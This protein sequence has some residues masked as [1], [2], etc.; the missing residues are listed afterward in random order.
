MERSRKALPFCISL[1][2]IIIFFA[3]ANLVSSQDLGKRFDLGDEHVTARARFLLPKLFNFER[4]KEVFHKIYDNVIENLVR[5]RLYLGRTFRAFITAVSY[6]YCKTDFYLG[7]NQMS[8]WTPEEQRAT[9]MDNRMFDDKDELFNHI[10]DHDEEF[11]EHFELP[12]AD[13]KEIER[14]FEEIEEHESEEPGYKEISREIRRFKRDVEEDFRENFSVRDLIKK[15]EGNIESKEKFSNTGEEVPG[16][17]LPEPVDS[18][19]QEV[20]EKE[21]PE[22]K[23]LV[24][25]EA[26]VIA[27]QPGDHF[28][29]S[30]LS[31][32]TSMFSLSSRKASERTRDI[33]YHDY[34]KSHC[35]LP[36]KDQKGCSCCYAMAA[37]AMYEWSYCDQ[38]GKPLAL[39]EQYPI[40]C[41]Q[42]V[43]LDGCNF[44]K[45]DM[46]SNFTT[47]YGLN[48]LENYP[49][50]GKGGECPFNK[51]ETLPEEMGYLRFLDEGWVH[52]PLRKF[53]EQL[54]RSPIVISMLVTDKI[55][56]YGGGVDD[57]SYCDDNYRHSALLIGSGREDGQEYWLFRFSFTDS[58]GENGHYK[59]N[60]KS[61]C[62]ARFGSVL[63]AK[64][65]GS[66]DENLNP[67]YLAKPVEELK[68]KY[69]QI[70]AARQI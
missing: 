50:I 16:D 53:E 61:K 37:I 6:K 44:A 32:A 8:D 60:K 49:Y 56:D 29:K 66:P 18:S 62:L 13:L 57:G 15:F 17:S 24:T 52:V 45:Y 2:F 43:G 42:D 54:R 70:E 10:E 55:H 67:K 12:V 26:E 5:R 65:R 63:K 19:P 36:L 34:R 33:V 35:Y 3:G 20:V 14:Q 22:P 41:G 39:S 7:I 30:V 25:D 68:K 23:Q 21:K 40:D 64:F 38:T 31:K 28:L 27:R 4:F 47:K 9:L 51:Q 11:G 1:Q 58:Y 48:T 59:L 69:L 46:L